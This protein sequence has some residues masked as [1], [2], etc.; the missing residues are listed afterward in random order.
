MRIGELGKATGV[1]VE[2]IRYYEKVGLL[3]RPARHSNGYRSYSESHLECLAFVRHCR[4]LDMTL[5]EIKCLLD[6]L[7]QPL[8]E[9]GDVDRLIEQQLIRVRTRIKSLR[10]LERQLAALRGCCATPHIA[11]DCGILHELVTAARQEGRAG[12]S[13]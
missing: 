11:A 5:A 10:A 3:P 13:L 6:F 4:A 8:A 1:D 9:C 7:G 2:T 12:N